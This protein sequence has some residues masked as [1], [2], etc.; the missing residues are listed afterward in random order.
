LRIYEK[1][2]REG[3]QLTGRN[4]FYYGRE[5]FAHKRYEDAAQVMEDFL[6]G[7]GW[8]ENKIEACLNLAEC[9]GKMGRRRPGAFQKLFV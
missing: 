6:Q 9:L 8:V 3:E 4:L 5:L 7:D 1:M 2:I